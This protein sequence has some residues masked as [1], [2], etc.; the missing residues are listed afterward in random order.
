MPRDH[1][2]LDRCRECGAVTRILVHTWDEVDDNG[3]DFHGLHAEH[4]AHVRKQCAEMQRLAREEWPLL[5][6]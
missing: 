3:D 1:S 2:P 6:F 5:P 4:V